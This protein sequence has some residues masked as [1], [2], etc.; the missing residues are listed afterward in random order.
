MPKKKSQRTLTKRDYLR[1]IFQVCAITF[2]ASPGAILAQGFGS[3]ISAVLP[4]VTTYFAALTTTALAE[5]YGGSPDAGGRAIEYVIITSIL[6][7]VYL[8]WSSVENYLTELMRYK[9]EAAMTD[10]MYTH[11]HELAFWR[12]DDKHTIDIYD[13]ANRFAQFFPYVFQQLSSIVTN[14]MGAILAL[15]A[16]SFVSWWMSLIAFVAIIPSVYIQIRISRANTKHWNK[17]VDTRRSINMIEW[18]LL[19]PDKM[20]ELRIYNVVKHLLKLRIT[21]RDKDEKARIDFERSYILKRLA[22][23][24]LQ[25]LAEVVTLVVVTVQIINRQQPIGQFL[26]V[27]QIVS[28]AL[29]SAESFVSSISRIDEDLAN[30]FDYQEFM[31]LDSAKGGVKELSGS[32]RQIEMNNISFSYHGQ[33]RQVLTNLTLTIK[34]NQHVAIVG[35]NGAG[36]STLVKLLIGLYEPSKGTILVN[37]TL[38][39]DIAISSWHAKLGVL[40]QDFLKYGF[41]TARENVTYGDVSKRYSENRYTQATKQAEANE[42]LEKLPKG[43]DSYINTWMEDEDGNNGTDLSGGQWQRLA[44]ARNFYRDADIII[45]DE[46]TSAIDALAEARIFKHLFAMKDKTVIT[47]SHRLTTVQKADVVYMMK[48][49]RIAETGTAKELIAK[50]GEFYRMFESQITK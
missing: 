39:S 14:F 27:Q 21:L 47:I 48:D 34:K 46:P 11:L 38:L 2:R 31:S 28:R 33:D 19:Q 23:S 17:N 26:Y 5:A 16:L 45:L 42:F 43:A 18:N 24:G 44:L 7:L 40:Q 20:A 13:R 6:G 32:I 35:E 29:T 8:A 25:A 15:L 4:I 37:D 12:Y 41:A 30:L 49:G 10:K 22:A 9:V 50:K 3:I 1:S 36:K